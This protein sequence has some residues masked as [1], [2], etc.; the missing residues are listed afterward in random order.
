MGQARGETS[1]GLGPNLAGLLCYVLGWLSGLVFIILE[2]DK[3]VRFHAIQSIVVFGVL[4]LAF[5]LILIPIIGWVFGWL[6]ILLAFVLWVVLMVRA[7]QGFKTKL[8][9]AGNFAEKRA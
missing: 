4:T 6:V 3:F 8:P 7:Y 5:G 9:A 1:A 2:K